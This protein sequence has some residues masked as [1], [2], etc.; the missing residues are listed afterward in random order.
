MSYADNKT[1]DS[2]RA[3]QHQIKQKLKSNT[4]LKIQTNV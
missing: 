3:P 2:N 1:E 4:K